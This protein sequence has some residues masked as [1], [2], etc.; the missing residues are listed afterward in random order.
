MITKKFKK[1]HIGDLA[2]SY[3]EILDDHPVALGNITCSKK[4]LVLLFGEFPEKI[5]LKISKED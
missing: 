4:M 3:E 1:R 2:V 5:T